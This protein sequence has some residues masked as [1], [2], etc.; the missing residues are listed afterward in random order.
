MT[1][2]NSEITD[3]SNLRVD[4]MLKIKIELKNELGH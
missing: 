1:E 3:K 4:I 2:I